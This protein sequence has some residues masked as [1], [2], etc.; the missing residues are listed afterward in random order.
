[1]IT[2]ILFTLLVIVGVALAFR[3]KSETRLKKKPPAKKPEGEKGIQSKTVIYAIL[4]LILA[5]STLLFVIHW[6]N[7]HEIVNIRVTDGSGNVV[8]YQAY[9]KS[10][11]GRRFV[12]LDGREVALGD[13]DRVEMTSTE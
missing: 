13:S 10:I 3:Q 7:Q 4:G 2:K 1:M 11:D 5:I 8:S 6:Q 12:T 9:K